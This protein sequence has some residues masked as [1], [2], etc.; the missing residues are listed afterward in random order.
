MDAPD[1]RAAAWLDVGPQDPGVAGAG[2]APLPL[3]AVHGWTGSK[4]DLESLTRLSGR[5]RV[6]VP[7]LPGHGDTP[8]GPDE[9]AHALPALTAHVLAVADHLGLDEFHLLGHSLGGLV[10]QHV[11]S[12]AT[13]RVA[14]L[15]LV[16]TGP[17][18]VADHT[19]DMVVAVVRAVRRGDRAAAWAAAT[20]LDRA[21]PATDPGPVTDGDPREAFVRDRFEGMAPQAII[22]A[23]RAVISASPLRAFLHGLDMPVLVCHGEG[24]T[25]WLPHQ[26]RLLAR[27]VP[28]ARYVVIPDA[29][30]SPAVENPDPLLHELEQLLGEADP[31]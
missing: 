2:P 15:A 5:R 18:A 30:H 20:G 27:M 21:A 1:L 3:L 11:A 13:H 17:G 9:A 25:S 4:E 29:L 16:G 14:S 7:D 22:G 24:D 28:G 6:V 12:R 23:G 19:A 31:R 10:A 8:P 26:Q